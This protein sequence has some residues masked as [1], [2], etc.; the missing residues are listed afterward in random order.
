MVIR[1]ARYLAGNDIG[2]TV[3]VGTFSGT[4][5]ELVAWPDSVTLY[6]AG[7]PLWSVKRVQ[8]NTLVTI[9]GKNEE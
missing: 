9:T 1:E 7:N 5:S 6:I 8:P 4:L 2:K 3:T